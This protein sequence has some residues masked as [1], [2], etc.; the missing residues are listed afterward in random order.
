MKAR[1]RA[2]TTPKANLPLRG[3][4]PTTP[5]IPTTPTPMRIRGRARTEPDLGRHSTA[6]R[7][8]TRTWQ[9]PAPERCKARR[10]DA[11]GRNERRDARPMLRADAAPGPCQL[12]TRAC[13]AG[14]T[15][16]EAVACGSC[17]KG[18]ATRS[19]KC[20]SDCSWGAWGTPSAC[21]TTEECT[22][23][24]TATRNVTCPCGGTKPQ[25]HT[26]STA[27]VWGGWSRHRQL[28]FGD[29]LHRARVLQHPRRPQR[30]PGQPWHLVQAEDL[31]L[32]PRR[33]ARRCNQWLDDEGCVLHQELYVDY[34]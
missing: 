17:G 27:C 26:C 2:K 7:L 15:Q 21:M 31:G 30:D 25:K 23:G 6:A 10:R 9:T 20:Q 29:L 12:T 5:P 28:R 33:S 14:E 4:T 34:L 8:P 3:T 24:T 18:T 1:T 22:S 19:R 16:S 11:C 13:T 32:L